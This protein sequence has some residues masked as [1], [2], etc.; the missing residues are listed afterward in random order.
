MSKREVSSNGSAV[1]EAESVQEIQTG[2]QTTT[3]QSQPAVR[4]CFCGC[5]RVVV[6]KKTTFAP[7]HDA[8]YKS[9]LLAEAR[10]GSAEARAT[11]I[12]RGWATDDSIDATGAKG[13]LSEE[14][15]RERQRERLTAKL[16]RAKAEV[17]RLE[18]E[19]MA[20]GG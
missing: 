8:T 2:E 18:Q 15:K 20:L 10:S 16:D 19:L 14:Q 9:R 3:E 7:G 1:A 4:T 11:L 12:E 5:G 6:G 17:A 13:K